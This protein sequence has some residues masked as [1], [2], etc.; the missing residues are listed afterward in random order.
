[1]SDN[2]SSG[3]VRSGG[4]ATPNRLAAIRETMD[5]SPKANAASETIKSIIEHLGGRD[6]VNP[7]SFTVGS[8]DSA[9][10]DYAA[11]YGIT[12]ES[13]EV[14]MT[15]KGI[16]HT[17]RPSKQDA[18]IAIPAKHLIEFPLRMSRMEIYHDTS[19]NKFVYFDRKRNEKFIVHPNYNITVRSS[20]Q[21]TNNYITASKTTRQEF[22]M[23][24]F[25]RIK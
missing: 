22:T 9:V 4:T 20:S 5:I 16:S 18:G 21:V 6:D 10:I 17:L 25:K 24:K 11:S 23:R 1:M 19:N 13:T 15:R 14:T 7:A 12:L 2:K 8:L 3:G